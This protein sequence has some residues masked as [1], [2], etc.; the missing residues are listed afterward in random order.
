MYALESFSRN[1]INSKRVEA[2][3]PKHKLTSTEK[4]LNTTSLIS[5]HPGE[6][7]VLG[8]LR[9]E[10]TGKRKATDALVH[11]ALKKVCGCAPQHVSEQLG[12]L[13]QIQ[14]TSPGKQPSEETPQSTLASR[15][16][17]INSCARFFSAIKLSPRSLSPRTERANPRWE[18]S[19]GFQDKMI[20]A[21]NGPADSM[22]HR[23]DLQDKPRSQACATARLTMSD[24]FDDRTPEQLEKCVEKGQELLEKIKQTLGE[25][26]DPDVSRMSQATKNVQSQAIP[27]KTVIGIVGA[28]GAGKSSIINA[29]LDEER[30]VPTSCMQACTAVVTEISYNNDGG[31]PYRAEIEFISRD[32]WRKTLKVLFQ[33][34]RDQPGQINMNEDSDSA[35][36]YA[37]VKAI[38]PWLTKE[39]IDE[40]PIETLMEHENVAYLGAKLSIE[41]SNADTF[42]KELQPFVDSKKKTAG[43]KERAEHEKEAEFWPLIRVVKLYV[44]A[45]ALAT[46]AVLVDLPG[47]HDSNQARAAVAKEYMK[48]CTGLLIVAPIT[49]A[50]NDK[51]AKTLL[52][53]SFKRQLKMDGGLNSVTF[54]CSRSDEISVTEAQDSLDLAEEQATMLAEEGDLSK[55][56]D[57]STEQITDLERRKDE[58]DAALDSADDE[59]EVWGT[60]RDDASVTRPPREFLKRKFSEMI[61]HKVNWSKFTEPG[62]DGDLS[63]SSEECA[64]DIGS[65]DT[66]SNPSDGHMQPLTDH[67]I[68]TKIAEITRTKKELR[69]EKRK[70][71]KEIQ[72]LKAQIGE[73]DSQ[74]ESI[75][76]EILAQ[77]IKGRNEYAR[78]VIARDYAAGIREL[79]QEL[80]DEDDPENFD[81]SM[82]A[83]D[84]DEV[85]RNLPVFCVS[86]RAY[87]KLMG[88][89]QRDKAPPGFQHIEE[90]EVPALQ[91]HCVHLTA[92]ARQAS[93][94]KFLTSLFQLLNSLRLWVAHGNVANTLAAMRLDQEAQI[95]EE[96]LN[97]LDSA[98]E[99]ACG[100]SVDEFSDQL[101]CKVFE[102][103][104]SATAAAQNKA[105]EI[106]RKWGSPVNQENPAAGGLHWS[107]YR[108]VVRRDGC[109]TNHR[110]CHNFNEQLIE[111]LIRQLARPWEYVFSRSLPIIFRQLP[112]IVANRITVFHEDVEGHAIRNGV[113]A[114]IFELLKQQI[115]VYKEKMNVIIKDANS[116]VTQQQRTFN[117]EFEPLMSNRM[118]EVYNA[119]AREEGRGCFKRMRDAM[120]RYVEDKKMVMFD[121]VANDVR[122]LITQ[123]LK[124]LKDT[125][126]GSL[127]GIS[128]DIRREYTNVV[129]RQEIGP[130]ERQAMRDKVLDIVDGAELVFEQ[131]LGLKE[132][133]TLEAGLPIQCQPEIADMTPVVRE[134]PGWEISRATPK[135]DSVEPVHGKP[136]HY[137]EL[138]NA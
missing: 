105:A 136:E 39:E 15:E 45:P 57:V 29:V 117:R 53:N 50:V 62:P 65:E 138:A 126:V 49:R 51:S 64:G 86:S 63:P 119:C 114:L 81:P 124:E 104:A 30:L 137:M 52:G 129:I 38:Y 97:S 56:K 16:S 41:S 24:L 43:L 22:C 82:D 89:F 6:L 134:E 107:T 123:M 74:Q 93:S 96:R 59:L 17:S 4:S 80:A 116:W 132:E 120:E 98:L 25:V 10:V 32:D 31:A 113:S 133:S 34:L 47:V 26:S 2:T 72:T 8:I 68:S 125:L 77:C 13:K 78:R 91:A 46:G 12:G 66:S 111:P 102:A 36:A 84:Y 21:Y 70:I 130:E 69:S 85:A 33:D 9:D 28:T 55:Q 87:Q 135:M 37:Q 48:Q 90:T 131:A 67:D 110:G 76:A 61:S 58:V 14:S 118:Q 127:K 101:Q 99:D 40:A 73:F 54:V 122:K 5:H 19:S 112:L 7:V 106:A 121:D 35:V 20:P 83:R 79:D 71:D 60:L 88:R 75:S 108:A 27:A 3:S 1:D 11:H 95:L 94:R 128:E 100:T 92:T 18:S 115:P 23:S 42:Q 103:Y 109:F 44:M